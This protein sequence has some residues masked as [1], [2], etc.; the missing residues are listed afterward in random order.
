[1]APR[2]HKGRKEDAVVPVQ[3]AS[4]Y[5]ASAAST[6]AQLRITFFKG[7]RK[8]KPLFSAD[9]LMLALGTDTTAVHVACDDPNIAP[10][11]QVIYL[12]KSGGA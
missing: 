3:T 1:M 2:K 7:K 8:L 6:T 10:N 12:R 4:T 11:V 5:A 9:V